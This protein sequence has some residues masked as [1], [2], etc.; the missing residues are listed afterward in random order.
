[1]GPV[2]Q[3][4]VVIPALNEER[5]IG[6]AIRSVLNQSVPSADYEVIVINDASEDRTAFAVDIFR[7]EIRVLHN[8]RRMG[9]PACLNV[10]IESIAAPVVAP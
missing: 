2:P 9:L 10:E 4:T 8:E 3:I 5:F 7:D 6:R 1:M